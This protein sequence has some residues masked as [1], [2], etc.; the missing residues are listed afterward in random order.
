MQI[1][2][3]RSCWRTSFISGLQLLAEAASHLPF[4]VQDPILGGSSAVE[5]YTG[6][7]WASPNLE[8]LTPHPQALTAE[9]FAI[10]FRWCERPRQRSAG[11]W[12]PG[13]AIGLEIIDHRSVLEAAGQANRLAIAIDVRPLRSADTGG[14]SLTVVGI[15]DLIAEQVGHWLAAGARPG[16]FAV[17]L[18]TLV[19]LGREGVGG[20]LREGYLQRRVAWQSGGQVVLELS[21][22]DDGIA[23]D[24]TVRA[25]NLTRMH[26]LINT[27]CSRNG[28]TSADVRQ[29]RRQEDDGAQPDQFN[30]PRNRVP[31]RGGGSNKASARIVP[32]DV[33][34]SSPPP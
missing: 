24:H 23:P 14:T 18:Q 22:L 2:N 32:F 19:G 29:S 15:E 31:R 4:G 5:L 10:G 20:P 16:E 13:L 27:W 12:H 21:S 9:L 26:V 8:V 7:L 6:G 33:A 25:M 34:S 1:Q 28:L 17:R 11:L 30:R 3:D